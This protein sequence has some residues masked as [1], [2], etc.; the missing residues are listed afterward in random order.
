MKTLRSTLAI[1]A[2]TGSLVAAAADKTAAAKT[3]D[4]ADDDAIISLAAYNV[5]ADRI[6][7]FGLR[8]KSRPFGSKPKT[9]V[10]FFVL[11]KFSPVITAVVPNTAA[12]KAG[13][14][15]GER[16]LKSDGKTTVGGAFSTGKFGQWS[17]TQKAKWAQVAA[18]ATNVA[19]TLEVETPATKAVRTVKLIVPTPPPHWGASVWRK[20]E[21]RVTSVVAEPGPLAQ[22]SREVL[23]H[24]IWTLLDEDFVQRVFGPSVSPGTAA[25]GYTWELA[26]HRILVTQFRG[27][28]DVMFEL[29]ARGIGFWSFLTSP[30]GELQRAWSW[31]RKG[32][33]GET[34][35]TEARAGFDHAL[36]FWTAKVH[37]GTGR[38]PF[39][40]R[41]GL[42]ARL[43]DAL[44]TGLRRRDQEL[45]RE[46]R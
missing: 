3:E 32:K 45:G 34:P 12:A 19:W 2:L 16:I 28:T 43:A 30:S 17:K 23:D 39:E 29:S 10:G 31:G 13:L 20:P 6:E 11:A 7:D 5:Q 37:P 21:G 46:P 38:W 15:P 42:P 35:L 44:P 4:A 41:A 8:V 24:G 33:S 22:L 25:S 14:R 40:V 1:L 18:G 36:D 9:A 26:G 27:R